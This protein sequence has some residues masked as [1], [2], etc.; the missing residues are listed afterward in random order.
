MDGQHMT[1]GINMGFSVCIKTKPYG[2]S[3]TPQNVGYKG[4]LL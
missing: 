1:I 3:D 2:K 4:K